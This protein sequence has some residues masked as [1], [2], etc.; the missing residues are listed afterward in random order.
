M[1]VSVCHENP[2]LCTC[3]DTS[4]TS[5][6]RKW[7]M[8]EWGSRIHLLLSLKAPQGRERRRQVNLHPVDWMEIN[9]NA[10]DGILPISAS[11]HIPSPSPSRGGPSSPSAQIPEGGRDQSKYPLRV[12]LLARHHCIFWLNSLSLCET[13]Q[14]CQIKL[15][16]CKATQ[17]HSEMPTF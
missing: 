4:V 16:S 12:P 8:I 6:R 15:F 10:L 14:H 11:S 7:R 5:P 3:F 17:Q 13:I 2:Q 1:C 9:L